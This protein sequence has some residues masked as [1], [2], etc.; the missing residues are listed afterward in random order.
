VFRIE[1]KASLPP[2]ILGYSELR[3]HITQKARVVAEQVVAFYTCSSDE[4]FSLM[5]HLEDSPLKA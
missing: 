3:L 5:G 2:L 4:M 1:G